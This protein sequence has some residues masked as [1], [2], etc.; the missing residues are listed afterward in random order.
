MA[1]NHYAAS[2]VH[3]EAALASIDLRKKPNI[4]ALARKYEVPETR[5]R[6]RW[7]GGGNRHNC[8]GAGK[9]LSNAQKL[10][11]CQI[12]DR[13][14]RRNLFTTVAAPKSRKLDSCAG[15]CWQS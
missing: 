8:G 2:E 1:S 6:A 11:L 14:R 15:F 9:K 10:A 7:N 13:R 3:T 4:A 5:L 12:I